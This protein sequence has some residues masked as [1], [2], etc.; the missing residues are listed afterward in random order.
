MS[1]VKT[2]I[3]LENNDYDTWVTGYS[4][5]DVLVELGDVEIRISKEMAQRI[6]A[7]SQEVQQ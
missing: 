3:T 4:D 1:R 5:G 6:Y 7:N 2:V